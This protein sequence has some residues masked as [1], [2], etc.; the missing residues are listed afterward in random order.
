M[1]LVTEQSARAHYD[2][3]CAGVRLPWRTSVEWSTWACVLF[4]VGLESDEVCH[5]VCVFE[6]FTFFPLMNQYMNIEIK[7][8]AQKSLYITRGYP[9]ARIGCQI[10]A[11]KLRQRPRPPQPLTM[12]INVAA[13]KT[14]VKQ[15]ARN[16]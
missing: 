1:R 12:T 8:L 6:T 3:E 4:R 5:L 2:A 11:S 13:S 14:R 10:P 15:G 9:L 7:G 16:K